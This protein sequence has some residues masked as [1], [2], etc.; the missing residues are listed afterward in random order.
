MITDIKTALEAPDY[1]VL[2]FLKQH[3]GSDTL[4]CT[5][6]YKNTPN[7]SPVVGVIRDI[8]LNDKEIT[9]PW[10]VK[11]NNQFKIKRDDLNIHNGHVKFRL[12]LLRKETRIEHSN[13]FALFPNEDSI[14]NY[15]PVAKVGTKDDEKEIIDNWRLKEQKF[16]GKIEAHGD[17]EYIIKDIRRSLD[18]TLIEV[19]GRKLEIFVGKHILSLRPN[20]CGKYYRF[21]WTLA[22]VSPYYKFHIDKRVALEEITPSKI[23]NILYEDIRNY[24]ISASRK[25]KKSLD[26]LKNQ[27]TASGKEVFIYELLQNANDYPVEKGDDKEPVSVEFHITNSSLIFMHSGREFD[28]ANVAAICSMG[29]GEKASKND[30][31]GYKGIG[32]KTVFIDSNYVYLKSGDFSFRYDY[33]KTKKILEMPWQIL[34]I[35][36]SLNEIDSDSQKIFTSADKKFRVKFALRPTNVTTLRL[37]NQNFES[38]FKDVFSTERAILFIP[39]I[40]DVSVYYSGKESADIVVSK[41]TQDW[42]VS[43]YKQYIGTIPPEL[44]ESLNERIEKEDGKI[45]EKYRDFRKTAVGFACKKDGNKLI[46]LEETDTCLYCYLPAKNAQWGLRFL[47][48]TDM[49][50]TGP[51]DDIE[52][53]QDMDINREITKIAGE[54]FVKWLK[55]LLIEGYDPASVFDLIPF[56]TEKSRASAGLTRYKDFIEKFEEG[57]YSELKNTPII[58][59]TTGGI[60]EYKKVEDVLYDTTGITRKN[61]FSNDKEFLHSSGMSGFLP[62]PEL[63]ECKSLHSLIGRVQK[64]NKDKVFDKDRLVGLCTRAEFNSWL[65]VPV[66]NARFL[67]YLFDSAYLAE[68]KDKAIFIKGND[69]SLAPSSNLIPDSI[70]LRADLKCFINPFIPYLDDN[71]REAIDDAR[72]NKLNQAG[73]VWKLFNHVE[74][75][76]FVS[77]NEKAKELLK[78]K[79]NSIPFYKYIRKNKATLDSAKCFEYKRLPLITTEGVIDN[80]KC[81]TKLYFYDPVGLEFQKKPWIDSRWITFIDKDYIADSPEESKKFFNELDVVNFTEQS[82]IK[83]LLDKDRIPEINVKIVDKKTNLDFFS[84]LYKNHTK[85]FYSD[86]S[87]SG[88]V[89]ITKD[90]EGNE[91]DSIPSEVPIF[92]P[93]ESISQYYSYSWIEKDWM[94]SLSESYYSELGD[95]IEDNKTRIIEFFKDKCKVRKFTV[96]E[97]CSAV[98]TH[99]LKK[100]LSNIGPVDI[101]KELESDIIVSIQERKKKNLDFFNF[102]VNNYSIFFCGNTQPFAN[103]AYP[104]INS[105]GDITQGNSSV[106]CCLYDSSDDALLLSNESWI[107]SGLIDVISK[108]YSK[109]DNTTAISIV[110]SGLGVVAFKYVDFLKEVV[111]SNK[112]SIVA[113]IKSFD[114][115]KAFHNYFCKNANE[116]VADDLKKLASWPIFVTGETGAVIVS[117]GNGLPAMSKE[118]QT[119]VDGGYVEIADVNAIHSDY[120]KDED[121]HKYWSDILGHKSISFEDI[122]KI[123]TSVVVQSKLVS[124]LTNEDDRSINLKFWRLIQ[125]LSYNKEGLKHLIKLPVLTKKVADEQFSFSAISGDCYI[126]DEYFEGGVG[127]SSL[128]IDHAPDAMII[129]HE[130]LESYD[131]ETKSSW[132]SF[133]EKAG[134]LSSNRDLILSILPNLSERKDSKTPLLI[135][136]NRHIID[137]VREEKIEELA[138]LN[139]ET[140]SGDFVCVKDVLF[141]QS[142]LSEPM[143]YIKLSD[144]I[145]DKYTQE[146]TKY[147]R[148]IAEDVESVNYISS[149]DDWASRKVKQYIGNQT[150]EIHNSFIRDLAAYENLAKLS[151]DIKFEDIRLRA[152]DG[153]LKTG[154]ELTL[155]SAYATEICDFEAYGI[156]SLDYVSDDYLK[157]EVSKPT[158]RDFFSKY[159]KVHRDFKETDIQFMAGNYDFALYVW[160]QYVRTKYGFE[161]IESLVEEGKFAGIACIPNDSQVCK[162]SSL[163]NHELESLCAYIADSESYFPAKSIP[164][165][166]KFKSGEEENNPLYKLEL[167]SQLSKNHCYEVLLNSDPD[168]D[169]RN[170]VVPRL[171]ELSGSIT[172]ADINSYLSNEKALWL[173]GQNE[174]VRTNLL[175]GIGTQA[176]DNYYR[177]HFQTDSHIIK[178]VG[179]GSADYE[180]V[181]KVL[182][183]TVLHKSDFKIVKPKDYVDQTSWIVESL[184]Q[185]SILLAAIVDASEQYSWYDSYVGYQSAAEKLK[186]MCCDNLTIECKVNPEISESDVIT[187]FFDEEEQTFYYV[188]GWQDKLVFDTLVTK[189][190]A[191]DVM[192]IP[193]N[194]TETIKKIID[195]NMVGK[196]LA[197]FVKRYC[198][199][200]SEDLEFRKAFH[201]CYPSVAEQL[202]WDNFKEKKKVATGSFREAVAFETEGRDDVI[203]EKFTEPQ[204]KNAETDVISEEPIISPA[205]N[206]EL[207]PE[208][209][210]TLTQQPTK[211]APKA[212]QPFKAGDNN[213]TIF[214]DDREVTIGIPIA[215]RYPEPPL[216][217]DEEEEEEDKTNHDTILACGETMEGKMDPIEKSDPLASKEHSQTSGKKTSNERGSA[218]HSHVGKSSGRWEKPTQ[219][220]STWVAQGNEIKPIILGQA[221]FED[222]E[223]EDV[224]RVLNTDREA[225]ADQNYIARKRFY[226]SLME[227][228]F[229]IS[230][231]KK[232]FITSEPGRDILLNDG[233]YIHRCSAAKGILYI[234]PSIW[235]KLKDDRCIICV[236]AG[237]KANEFRY[238]RSQEELLTF[239][240]DTAILIQVTGPNKGEIM[241]RMYSGSLQ[242]RTGDLYAMIPIKPQGAFG[243]LYTTS[244]KDLDEATFNLENL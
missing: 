9:L 221:E 88:L 8:K 22:Q 78:K 159:I 131:D 198:T 11:M 238:F 34:P 12:R 138:Q 202:G 210:A 145:S 73:Y 213:D 223:Y 124:K 120:F 4:E 201:S 175:Y 56:L 130:Y 59:S 240:Q 40:K 188:Y 123:L 205:S 121:K 5:G 215:D 83:V 94:E 143:A 15:T 226:D 3:L 99:N 222:F 60:L 160:S 237:K 234:S 96:G 194:D 177:R 136:E 27:L 30:A 102:L 236:Y 196:R 107:P 19:G 183:V 227:S 44:T 135:Y 140:K 90:N 50:P 6:V 54:Q 232:D 181:C 106:S 92:L 105:A 110:K 21:G 112:A 230:T 133:W 122:G 87:L 109:S 29:E 111:L 85:D 79:E 64:S 176:D 171:V 20:Q 91:T 147:F 52:V 242:S 164:Y 162:S 26:T 45:P 48:N 186:F 42:C 81:A 63:R 132:M 67:D 208:T 129:S 49:I 125:S 104:F 61:V 84:L 16:I 108:D 199:H 224:A 144:E 128:L 157:L 72:C 185:K 187:C 151:H 39:N 189:L 66:N 25:I 192:N 167:C 239:V 204:I 89:L 217:D 31:I 127:L 193:G 168:D 17:G 117:D 137:E 233:R 33:L 180:E 80:S 243:M 71:T 134:L 23:V 51:R 173:N 190:C 98:V 229:N 218:H 172:S 62:I 113:K 43:K 153:S 126:S 197:D 152:K 58:P 14:V 95:D 184:K 24:P 103:K 32:F 100:I 146:Q 36:T 57:F 214:G 158:L 118:M 77:S 211:E 114:E 191:E 93:E 219:L 203:P 206:T 228:G 235:N 46:G 55:D 115:N 18:F 141:L 65:K 74:F 241:D 195:E 149:N 220:D 209:A 142:G 200:M 161:T 244:A 38:L 97:F 116:F 41:E 1:E 35:P 170:M 231:D 212:E 166:I 53:G 69:S 174:I 82:L 216:Y 119:I 86:G 7:N 156:T 155:G 139:V 101:S 68:F 70:D 148:R 10:G 179:F 37:S 13:P 182:G 163:Y 207:S 47:M 154:S 2:E 225:I 150:E 169:S 28:A 75:L 165:T 178:E 76:K